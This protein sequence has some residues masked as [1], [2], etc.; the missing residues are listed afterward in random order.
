MQAIVEKHTTGEVNALYAE[1]LETERQAREHSI[2]H[3]PGKPSI[4]SM[5]DMKMERIKNKLNLSVDVANLRQKR[6]DREQQKYE[7]N[8]AYKKVTNIMT[9]SN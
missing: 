4:I 7:S 2:E 9:F 8:L 3:I 1:K 6:I 5:N